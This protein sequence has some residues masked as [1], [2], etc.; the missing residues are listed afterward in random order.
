MEHERVGGR[1]KLGYFSP[2]F[3]DSV[4]SSW[5]ISSGSPVPS[6]K[7]LFLWSQLPP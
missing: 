2:S 7:F 6:G 4:C 5:S 1:E 3:L